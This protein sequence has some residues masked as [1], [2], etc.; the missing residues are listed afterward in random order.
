MDQRLLDSIDPGMADFGTPI[1]RICAEALLETGSLEAA[2]AQVQLTPAALRAHLTELERMSAKRGYAP[3]GDMS[4]P[5]PAGFSVKGVSTLYNA[6]GEVAQQWVKTKRDDEE[7]L[8]ALLSAVGALSSDWQSKA[9]PIELL[10][11]A[12]ERDNDL[13]NVFP[14][15]DPHLGMMSWAPET[16]HNFDLKIAEHN[17]FEAVSRLVNLAPP[18]R[19]ALVVNLG[20]F[21]H[22]D[23]K[24]NTTTAGTPVDVDGRWA[25]IIN[26]GI[27]V[28]RRIIDR[29]LET[30][31]EVHVICEIGNHDSHMSIVLGVCLAQ[32]YERE[33]RVTIDTSP[34]K[35]HWYRFGGQSDWCH[36]W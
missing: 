26:V 19:R 12:V 36:A 17:L 27:R 7:R 4:K 23:S 34:A 33:P 9:E 5:T 35:F 30:H 10:P 21:F 29:C 25:K 15:G 31:D 18:A 1:Q 8:Q 6:K 13:L 3:G 2:A 16:G 22:A 20:D 28:M 14:M 24:A 11:S 32:F